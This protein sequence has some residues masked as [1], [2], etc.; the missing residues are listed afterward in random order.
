MEAGSLQAR[1][2]EVP[3]HPK[4]RCQQDRSP[5]RL[6]AYRMFQFEMG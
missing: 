1:I 2:S 5:L 4:S 6:K 3:V